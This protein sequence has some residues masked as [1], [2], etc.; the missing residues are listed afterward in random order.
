LDGEFRSDLFYR[1]NTFPIELPPL[2][3]RG[4][5][6]QLLAEHFI[7]VHS[8]NLRREITAMSG[9]MMQRLRDYP[10]PGNVRELESVIQRALISSSG[11]VLDLPRQKS[12]ESGEPESNSPRVLSTT[13]ADL[14]VVERDHILAV[15]EESQ[16]KIAGES[17]AAAKLGIPPSTLRSKMKKLAIV[18]PGR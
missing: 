16:W 8:K 10:W 7:N 17:G 4:N 2:R 18:R 6:I 5:D 13:I 9:N 3:A 14:R 15:L 11:P 1:I 12:E